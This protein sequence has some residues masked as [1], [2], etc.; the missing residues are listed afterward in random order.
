[1]TVSNPW[2]LHGLCHTGAIALY[3]TV[4]AVGAVFLYT[5]PALLV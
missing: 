3:C 4:G 1:M 5:A 2:P